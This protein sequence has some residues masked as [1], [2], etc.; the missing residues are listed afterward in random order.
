VSSAKIFGGWVK[1]HSGMSL[2][3]G[4]QLQYANWAK[5]RNGVAPA[6]SSNA[7]FDVITDPNKLL[8]FGKE[9]NADVVVYF[10]EKSTKMDDNYEEGEMTVSQAL[11]ASRKDNSETKIDAAVAYKRHTVKGNITFDVIIADVVNGTVMHRQNLTANSLSTYLTGTYSPKAGKDVATYK[12]AV[13]ELENAD[14]AA[15]QGISDSYAWNNNAYDA[16][17]PMAE[18]K[19]GQAEEGYAEWIKGAERDCESLLID[20]ASAEIIPMVKEVLGNIK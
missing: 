10:N 9:V 19:K 14:A 1:K 8:D 15:S 2:F 13:I 12:M 11:D 3:K 16:K 18:L 17:D 20:G 4:P 7:D 6:I 5:N